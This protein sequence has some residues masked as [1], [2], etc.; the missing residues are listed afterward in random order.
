MSR[1]LNEKLENLF[2]FRSAAYGGSSITKIPPTQTTV[3]CQL[4]II[5]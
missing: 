2:D 4:L 5:N 3:N 1:G